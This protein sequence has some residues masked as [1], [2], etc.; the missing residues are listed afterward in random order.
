ME[1]WEDIQKELLR[2]DNAGASKR[3]EL[4]VPQMMKIGDRWY[5]FG[6]IYGRSE[7]GVGRTSYWKGEADTLIDDED[8]NSKTEQF[9]TGDDLCAG[10]LVQVG[11]RYYIYGWIPYLSH[12]S[13]GGTLNIAREVYQLPNGDLATR[14][15]PYMT[16]LL[17]R[18][19]IYSL[20][21]GN[22]TEISGDWNVTSNL[23]TIESQGDEISVVNSKVFS[24][25]ELPG[26]YDRNL[27]TLNLSIGEESN[28][29]GIILDNLVGLGKYY[30]YIDKEEE[31]LFIKTVEAGGLMTKGEIEL[32]GIDYEDMEIK[33]IAEGSIIE[34][35]INNQYS[36]VSKI[37]DFGVNELDNYTISLFGDGD[38]VKFSNLY[39]NKLSSR[40]N[41]YD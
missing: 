12:G 2:F 16:N 20:G 29:A 37:C 3:D 1:Y 24:K 9:L 26:E 7:N 18:G 14:L 40:E 33:I 11:N 36:L 13:W 22:E 30:I 35:F 8:W 5:I 19:K 41:I 39:V 32:T 21:D 25:L 34:V 23:A 31:K 10:Q 6:S 27:I 15:D 28:M 17:N 4:E 38:N